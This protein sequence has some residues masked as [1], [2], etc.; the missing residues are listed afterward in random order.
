MCP[1]SSDVELVSSRVLSR[2][3]SRVKG[4]HVRVHVST[5]NARQNLWDASTEIHARKHVI[6]M[7]IAR[8]YHNCFSWGIKGKKSVNG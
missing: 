2:D 6:G 3:R 4:S 7:R 1:R 5:L 8:D